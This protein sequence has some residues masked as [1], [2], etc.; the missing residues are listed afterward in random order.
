MKSKDIQFL[1]NLIKF[2]WL[3]VDIGKAQKLASDIYELDINIP[4]NLEGMVVDF[5]SNRDDLVIGKIALI[6]GKHRFFDVEKHVILIALLVEKNLLSL[7][8][9]GPLLTGINITESESNI[10]NELKRVI[11]VAWLINEDS[12]DGIME[13]SDDSLLQDALMKMVAFSRVK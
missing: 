4:D 13:A 2:C 11:D 6:C 8:D 7:N 5:W 9:A 12:N 1:W 10:S 3:T